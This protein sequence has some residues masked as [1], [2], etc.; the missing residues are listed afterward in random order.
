MCEFEVTFEATVSDDCGVSAADVAV[1]ISEITG[2]ATLG[3]PSVNI[4][5]NGATTVDV[6][7]SV[8]VFDLTDSPA[9]VSIDVSATDNCGLPA[10]MTFLADVADTT[11]PTIEVVL[12][13]DTLW[14]PNHKMV[15]ITADVTVE[16]NCSIASFVLDSV[17][18]DE[19]DDA[20]GDGS[21]INDIQQAELGTPDQSFLLRA[22]RMGNG[23]GR[24]YTATY[25]ATDGSGNQATDSAT[26]E[27][28][29]SE[30]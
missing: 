23:D 17:T 27:V 16:D 13:P 30:Q 1:N 14:S 3:I 8:L 22:E 4:V 26:V 24:T 28:P 20:T 19:P 11:P 12:S 21:F 15:E 2:N 6:S 18:S 9:T 5:Q 25:T 29:H 10:D 7:G